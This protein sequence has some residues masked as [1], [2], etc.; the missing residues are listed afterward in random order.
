MAKQILASTEDV[1][2]PQAL[3]Q[4][5]RPKERKA[6]AAAA[7]AATSPVAATRAKA[8]AVQPG[9][10]QSPSARSAFRAPPGNVSPRGVGRGEGGEGHGAGAG[11]G[12]GG[13]PPSPRKTHAA[14]KGASASE[15]QAAPASAF[16][17]KSLM[18][19]LAVG[20]ATLQAELEDD[21]AQAPP[22]ALS[23]A[24]EETVALPLPTV[25]DAADEELMNSLLNEADPNA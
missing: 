18:Q 13:E 5:A 20:R 21:P 10:P 25:L 14:T 15:R 8:A 9:E 11:A 4:R 1:E 17:Y 2:Q 7:A 6:K 23:V 19:E 24:V 12:G 22:P 16:D 3:Q